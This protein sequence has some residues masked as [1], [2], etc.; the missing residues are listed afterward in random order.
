MK[1]QCVAELLYSVS[2]MIYC[3]EDKSKTVGFLFSKYYIP[4]S[5]KRPQTEAAPLGITLEIGYEL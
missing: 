2:D 3:I 4:Y 5:D 1:E